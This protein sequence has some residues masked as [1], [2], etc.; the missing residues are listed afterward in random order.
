MIFNKMFYTSIFFGII[1][2]V[3]IYMVA[4]PN[5]EIESPL[6]YALSF[7]SVLCVLLCSF[8]AAN[9]QNSSIEESIC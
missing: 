1:G 4:S 2:L 5:F 9:S 8:M 3:L 6:K 7:C